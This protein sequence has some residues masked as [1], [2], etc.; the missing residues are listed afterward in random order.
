[1]YSALEINAFSEVEYS[2]P[3]DTGKKTHALRRLTFPQ[4]KENGPK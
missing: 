2:A 4:E 3:R 1:M